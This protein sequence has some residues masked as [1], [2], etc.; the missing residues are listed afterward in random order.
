MN[1]SNGSNYQA[2]SNNSRP[3]ASAP[4]YKDIVFSSSLKHKTDRNLANNIQSVAS[5]PSYKDIDFSSSLKHKADRN[6][7]NF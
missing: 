4:S 5:A 1:I 7:A 3:V 2:T 6:L